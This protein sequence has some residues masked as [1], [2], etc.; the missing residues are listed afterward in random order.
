MDCLRDAL[1]SA[2]SIHLPRPVCQEREPLT[3]PQS[4]SVPA[5]SSARTVRPSR[6]TAKARGSASRSPSPPT[7]TFPSQNAGRRPQRRPGKP[8]GPQGRRPP[9]RATR[10]S[11]GRQGSG[12]GRSPPRS[13]AGDTSTTTLRR[14]PTEGKEGPVSGQQA[15]RVVWTAP[16]QE[17]ASCRGLCPRAPRIYRLMATGTPMPRRWLRCRRPECGESQGLWGMDPPGSR[18]QTSR[19][20]LA[21]RILVRQ[22]GCAVVPARSGAESRVVVLIEGRVG[23]GPGRG[24]GTI[25]RKATCF[26]DARK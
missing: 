8:D 13:I 11:R 10:P 24:S 21:C 18:D 15:P 9:S 19:T 26:G 2:Q 5:Q 1:A 23:Q 25:W 22:R 12:F 4:R 17:A 6:S 14:F 3:R 16:P 20:V 7:I